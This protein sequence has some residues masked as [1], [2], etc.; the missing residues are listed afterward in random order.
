VSARPAWTVSETTS[1]KPKSWDEDQVTEHFPSKREALSSVP[2]TEKKKRERERER[3]S[4]D[5]TG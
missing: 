1:Y 5:Y 3:R 4:E 2:S